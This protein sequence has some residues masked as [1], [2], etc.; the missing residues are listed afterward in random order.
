MPITVLEAVA[1]TAVVVL[2]FAWYLTYT[3]ARLHRLHTRVEGSLAALDA[4][5]VRRAEASV[6]LANGQLLDPA[7]SLLLVG[8]ASDCLDAAADELTGLE[9][10]EGDLAQREAL[11]S[12]LTVTLRH[13][14]DFLPSTPG[15]EDP[16]RRVRDAHRRVQLARRFYNDAVS[17]VQR[18][19]AGPLV[20]AFRLAG[21]AALPRTVEFD[22]AL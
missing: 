10:A 14:L 1:L 15:E 7:T 9:W 13:A 16:V 21:H 18:L 22:D 4:Q 20:R 6:E 17:D 12:D 8:A 19:R 3:A 2:A 5:L 11:E